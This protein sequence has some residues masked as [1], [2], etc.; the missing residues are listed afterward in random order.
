M[1]ME[2]HGVFTIAPDRPFL[3]VLARA[4]LEHGFPSRGPCAPDAFALARWTILVPTRR[5]ARALE[6]TFLGLTGGKGLMLPRIRPI[7][8]IDEDLLMEEATG[9]MQEKAAIS[10]PAQVLLLVDLVDQ[11]AASNPQSR[12]AQEI[13]SA[14]Q[15]ALGLALTL[16]ELLDGLDAEGI[17]MDDI[18]K[19]YDIEKARHREEIIAFLDI[20]RAAYPGRLASL[21]LLGPQQRRAAILNRE[22]ERLATQRPEAPIIAAGSTGTFAATRALLKAITGL[23]N[24]AVV[25]PGLDTVMDE[26]SWLAAGPTHPQWAMKQVLAAIGVPRALVPELGGTQPSPRHWLASETM[27]PPDTSQDWQTS[28]AGQ[29]SR[30]AEAMAGVELVEARSQPE[31][32]STVALILR[33]VLETPGRTACLVTPDRELARRVKAELSRWNVLIDD[34]AGEPLIHQ[35]AAALLDLLM[36]AAAQSFAGPATAALLRHGLCRF[37]ETPERARRFASLIELALF[38]SGLGS[39]DIGGLVHALRATLESGDRLPLALRAA[40]DEEWA[41]AIAFADRVS[42]AL[43]PLRDPAAQTLAGHIDLF[44]AACEAMAGEAFREGEVGQLLAET[45]DILREESGQLAQCGQARA[46]GMIRHWLRNTPVRPTRMEGA[47]LSILG[48]LEARLIRADLVVLAGLNEGVWPGAPD[49]G[50]WLNRPMREALGMSQPEREIGQTAHDFVQAFGAPQVKLVWARRQGDAPAIPSRWILRLRMIL[51]QTGVNVAASPW[52]A[53]AGT[54]RE[55][56]EVRP[57]AKPR[58]CPPVAA[59]PRQ[60]SVTRIETL[61][62]DPYAIYA[63]HVLRLEPL[64]PVSAA[65]NPARRG[66]IFHAA[67]GDVLGR[68]PLA[69]PTDMEADLL[70]AGAHHFADLSDFPALTAFWW[71]RFRK[72]ARWLADEESRL[73]ADAQRVLSETGGGMDLDVAGAT[74]KLTCRADRID[75]LADGSARIIDYKT[76]GVPSGKEVQAGLA[77]Q[78]TLQAAILAAGGMMG[79]E[80]RPVSAIAYVHVDGGEP[81]GTYKAPKLDDPVMVLAENHRQGLV[82]K[83]TAYASPR[84][85]YL[86]RVMLKYEGEASDY[87]HLSRYAEWMLSG[88]TR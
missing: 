68:H 57:V 28:L 19:L 52:A 38:R 20:A 27:R 30:V 44:V 80:P 82:R 33:E 13:A 54:L 39:P 74:F 72:V 24:G 14:P 55:P 78:L 29:G 25:L 71:P 43:R 16:A 11:W 23:P 67:I 46:I 26:A 66:I 69:P 31:Q 5:A 3:D 12:L 40:S 63:R 34:S 36:D 77:P 58:P 9:D 75:L 1:T 79:V 49:P 73:R 50:P 8:D 59:R 88:E 2:A 56:G 4:I 22:A 42:A 86:P 48:L 32:A 41:E 15:Q 84:Q 35:D 81:P 61:I 47:R 7:G 83:L 10:R 76:G 17:G 85:P 62:R 53:L 6:E 18:P 51:K 64:D 87:D 70:A 21:N 45:L 37:G 65:P 60:L